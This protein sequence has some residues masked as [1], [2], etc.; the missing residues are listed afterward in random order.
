MIG[1]G[2]YTL[3]A[4]WRL[5]RA[6]VAAATGRARDLALEIGLDLIGPERIDTLAFMWLMTRELHRDQAAELLE[7]LGEQL[8]AKIELQAP[9]SRAAAAETDPP[10][11]APIV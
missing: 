10:D 7:R 3:F 11:P 9:P 6:A 2:G 1:A 5:A 8:G 4:S